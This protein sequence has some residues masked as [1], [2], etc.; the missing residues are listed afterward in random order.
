MRIRLAFTALLILPLAAAQSVY[1]QPAGYETVEGNSSSG[2][3]FSYASAR[4]QQSDSNRIGVVMPAISMLRFRRDRNAGASGVARTLNV[5]VTMGKND[6]ATFSSSFGNNWLG[7]PT[8]VYTIRS[9]NLPDITLPPPAFPAPFT[10]PIVFDVPYYYDGVDSLMWE[11]QLGSAVT[12]TYSLDWVSAAT[13]TNGA[14]T[15]ALGT[16]CTTQNGAMSLTTTFTATATA[17]NLTWSTASGP[18]S[19][20]LTV[21]LGLSD[22]NLAIPGFCANIRSDAIISVPLGDTGPTGSLAQTMSFP[23]SP[24]FA[25]WDMFTQTL[26]PDAS[27]AAFPLALSNGRRSP[28]PATAGGPGSNGIKRTY[29]TTSLNATTGSTPSVS[30]VVTEINY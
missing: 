20:P 27:Q 6:I 1:V 14:T 21:L 18:S 19:V 29:S 3:P 23:W 5:G 13:T 9:T 4:V 7:A 25:G 11:I 8:T 24:A 26:A 15:T 12:G 30:A 28:M 17:L 16:G 10:V 22:P 2:I